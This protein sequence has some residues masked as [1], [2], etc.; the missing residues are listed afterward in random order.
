MRPP[1]IDRRTFIRGGVALGGCV[2]LG[3]LSPFD[4][5]PDG[6][7]QLPAID[8][9]P[10][11]N[12]DYPA[13]VELLPFGH[14]VTSGN[15]L[16]HRV[17]LWTRLTVSDARGWAVADPQG[18]TEITV[19][20][21]IATDLA[22][23]DV[24]A[25]GRVRTDISLDWTVK[26]DAAGLCS[27][28]TYY[29]AFSALGHRSIVGRTR[30]APVPGDA[31]SELHI[32]HAA[33]SSYWSMDFHPYARIA[34]RD[35]LDLFCHAGDHIYDYPDD[36]QWYRPRNEVFDP[37]YV[38]FRDWRNADECAR[39]YALYYADPDLLRAH[40]AVAFAIMPDQHDIDSA[41]DPHSGIEFTQAEAAQ[42]FWLWTPSRPPLPDGS[43]EFG[44]PPSPDTNIA[45]VPRQ[46]ATLFHRYLPYGD[47]ADVILIDQRRH[48]DPEA[49]SELGRLLGETQ[50]AWL[51]R[52][53]LASKN[54]RGA[55]QRV[56]VN[57]I[58]MAQLLLFT[59]P[60]PGLFET[61]GLNPNGPELYAGVW[62]GRIFGSARPF[63]SQ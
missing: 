10:P 24:V 45:Y 52:V 62:L 27:A 4:A 47:L 41:T 57:Q 2:A 35:D 5:S 46:A 39:R 18:L 16:A 40:Q 1:P 17:I 61:L 19:D 9:A 25:G 20:W 32:A 6:P 26:V 38:D 42:V 37:E 53:L 58:N 15:P 7:E 8:L 3:G 34:Q 63:L 59:A 33:C 49:P 30:T 11:Q 31:V 56:I 50:A 13:V 23:E 51:R 43:G 55:V 36:K 22:L 21:L 28:T 44:P 14:G 54:E 60:L 12:W 48:G 29:Y